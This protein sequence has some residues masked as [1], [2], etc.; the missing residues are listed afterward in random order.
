MQKEVR[1]FKAAAHD[2]APPGQLVLPLDEIRNRAR[3]DEFVMLIFDGRG[4]VS[5]LPSS[6]IPAPPAAA[7][8]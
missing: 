6:N 8:P 7:K 5:Y 2:D 3:S 4:N 1:Y